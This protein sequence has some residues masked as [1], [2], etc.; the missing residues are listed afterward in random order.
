MV[1]IPNVDGMRVAEAAHVLRNLGFA[2]QV[3]QV[4]PFDVVFNYSPQGQAPKGSTV[5]LDTG[6]PRFPG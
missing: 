4:G 1:T 3:A 2:V 5:T 6:L